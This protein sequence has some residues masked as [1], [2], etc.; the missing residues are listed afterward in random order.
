MWEI[1][2]HRHRQGHLVKVRRGLRAEGAYG[3]DGWGQTG[4]T[5]EGQKSGKIS[6]F[7]ESLSEERFMA[8]LGPSSGASIDLVGS[9]EAALWLPMTLLPEELL[10]LPPS[11]HP[12]PAP[13][14]ACWPKLMSPARTPDRAVIVRLLF[15]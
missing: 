8:L 4:V 9:R 15:F 5:H 6:V 3:K 11:Q 2:E 7:S 14:R 1:T 10:S 13:A 12:T